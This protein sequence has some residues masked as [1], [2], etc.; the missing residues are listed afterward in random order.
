MKGY[1]QPATC[2]HREGW[3]ALRHGEE[4]RE[5]RARW[6]PDVPDDGPDTDTYADDRAADRAAAK[7]QERR[8]YDWRKA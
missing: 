7:E 6:G 4:C 5:F 1:T 3:C 8:E 2:D